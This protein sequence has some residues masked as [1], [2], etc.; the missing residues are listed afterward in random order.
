M[1][2]KNII[3]NYMGQFYIMFIGIFMLPFYLK[4][5]GTEEYGLVGF[6]TMLT[7]WMMLLDMGLSTTLSREAAKLKREK[8]REKQRAMYE[9][10]T[11]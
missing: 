8:E 10:G 5:L 11:M 4:Y 2:K 9:Q 7:S 1:L 6:F 3:F